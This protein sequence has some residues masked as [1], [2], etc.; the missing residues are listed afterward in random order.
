MQ[1]TKRKSQWEVCTGEEK[2]GIVR[3]G[4]QPE[5]LEA[6]VD[7][8]LAT[9]PSTILL[10]NASLHHPLPSQLHP[11]HCVTQPHVNQPHNPLLP[12]QSPPHN[13]SDQGKKK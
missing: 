10:T 3:V 6:S 13:Q 1:T 2:E 12:L 4:V 11:T 8:V 5:A 7:L 9:Q